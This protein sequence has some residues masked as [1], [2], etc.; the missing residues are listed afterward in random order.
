MLEIFDCLKFLVKEILWEETFSKNK[1]KM[2]FLT[3]KKFSINKFF[4]TIRERYN[5]HRGGIQRKTWCMP[6]LIIPHL[7]STPESTPTH[8]PWGNPIPESTLT[9]CQSRLYPPVSDFGFGLSTVW[10]KT[11]SLKCRAKPELNVVVTILWKWSARE[12]EMN[13]FYSQVIGI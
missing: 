3:L 12:E 11:I 2:F 5:K 8:L 13:K 6:E 1:N 9:L 7:T 4:F 10:I